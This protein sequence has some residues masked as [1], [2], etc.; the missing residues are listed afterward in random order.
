MIT[1]RNICIFGDPI[2][3]GAWSRDG[4]WAERLQK[5]LQRRTI[6]S[7][8]RSYYFL[9]NVSIPGNTTGDVLARFDAECEVREPHI[10][11]FAVG[12]NDASCRANPDKPRIERAR[13]EENGVRLIREAKA[14]AERVLWVGLT[15]VD[16]AR[17]MPFEATYFL[18]AR[19]RDYDAVIKT[20]CAKEGVAYVDIA[21]VVGP[22]ELADGL[23][24]NDRGHEKMCVAIERA[25]A[26]CGVQ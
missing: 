3:Y 24:P 7:G 23:H 11:V 25:L 9:Y 4:G 18:N 22:E 15:T 10:I 12:I 19:I 14:R 1:T 16:E 20:V 21:G 6:D 8:F 2:A 17:A 26:G 13:F 5:I